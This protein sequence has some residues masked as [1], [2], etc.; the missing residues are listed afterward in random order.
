M[1]LSHL[2]LTHFRN[3]RQ[4]EFDFAGPLT[5]FQ[6]Q[7]A[8]GKTNLL[9]AIYFMA[10][11]KP[12]HAQTERE[13]VNWDAD[14]EPIPYMRMAAT[15][16]KSP[17]DTARPLELEILLTQRD[18]S[19]TFK[20]QIRINGVNRRGID[21]VGQMRAVLFLPEDIELISGSPS[22]RR[23]YLDISLCQSVREYTRALSQYQKIVTRR[24][25]LLRSLRERNV[26]PSDPAVGAQLDFWD[27]QLVQ[28]GST[29]V[30]Q[31]YNY[32]KRLEAVART[33]HAELSGAREAL[34]LQYMPSF[35]PGY[36]SDSDF[37][38]LREGTLPPAETAA[39]QETLAVSRVR[40]QFQNKLHS[41]R[42][43]ELAAG[44]TLYGPHRDDLRLLA[45]GRDLRTYGSR[46]Q[47]RTAAL[48][49][50]LAEVQAMT[51][52]TGEAPLLLL[53][54]VMSEL[55]SLRRQFLL[56]ALDGVPQ[57]ILTTTDLDT[58][59]PQ[60]CA[61]AQLFH[62]HAGTV[63]PVTA[64]FAPAPSQANAGTA[65][66]AHAKNALDADAAEH[67]QRI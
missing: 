9:E 29:V 21:L 61:Q 7:N 27:E 1:Y 25:S 28:H 5:L 60:F 44:S 24:N 50:K 20:K 12:V 11:S 58:F 53:D 16:R 10:T 52:M 6:G 33:R 59:S 48:S 56:T 42:R 38:R 3:Y 8:Q 15:V 63:H 35:N 57:S 30:A 13:V 32:I 41:R 43:R 18:N 47:Q 4:L 2:S 46:G 14:E 40:A 64:P 51:D 37:E 45:N 17:A 19:Q 31:R 26:N 22:V 36:L 49:L 54:D 65:S 55:D 23:R 67:S 62:V 34:A 39:P 66:D